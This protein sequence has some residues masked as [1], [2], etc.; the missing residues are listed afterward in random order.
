MLFHTVFKIIVI[1]EL[2]VKPFK[3]SNAIETGYPYDVEPAYSLRY[4]KC[5]YL[6]SGLNHLELS[7][8]NIKVCSNNSK[9]PKAIFTSSRYAYVVSKQ[10]SSIYGINGIEIGPLWL[11]NAY[12]NIV[13]VNIFV[14]S[15]TSKLAINSLILENILK[16]CDYIASKYKQDIINNNCRKDSIYHKIYD[17]DFKD[18]KSYKGYTISINQNCH[19]MEFMVDRNNIY[20]KLKLDNIDMFNSHNILLRK[21]GNNSETIKNLQHTFNVRVM[22]G[23]SDSKIVHYYNKLH[24]LTW[25]EDHLLPFKVYYTSIFDFLQIIMLRLTRKHFMYLMHQKVEYIQDFTIRW[26]EILE[27]FVTILHPENV[28]YIFTI[29]S[30]IEYFVRDFPKIGNSVDLDNLTFYF[31][32]F[33]NKLIHQ[34]DMFAFELCKDLECNANTPIELNG[35]EL[36][37]INQ[38]DQR[39]FMQHNLKSNTTVEVFS[40]ENTKEYIKFIKTIFNG[41]DFNIIRSFMNYIDE[42]SQYKLF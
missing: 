8:S 2:F 26:L 31:N 41:F 25:N 5:S 30:N 14:H 28:L 19:K 37:T 16:T 20:T 1:I 12:T 34:L 11:L 38:N 13:D 3:L 22:W 27:E 33:T 9:L 7:I 42:I 15:K 10:L 40:I 17:K 29:K 39:R 24:E 32:N 21:L 4:L 6:Y 23:K 36:F 18:F 35:K